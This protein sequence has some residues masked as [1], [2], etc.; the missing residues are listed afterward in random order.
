MKYIWRNYLQTSDINSTWVSNQMVDNS[1]VIGACSNCILN[2]ALTPDFNIL[3]EEHCKTW[4]ET[5]RFGDSARLI[6]DIY[7]NHYLHIAHDILS[8]IRNM[9]FL[10]PTMLTSGMMFLVSYWLPPILV[11]MVIYLQQ[12]DIKS[13]CWHCLS[14]VHSCHQ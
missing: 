14:N 10:L 4:R 9:Y 2:L 7:G 1:D 11:P 3:Q 13:Y 8:Y 12:D 6:L 5:F